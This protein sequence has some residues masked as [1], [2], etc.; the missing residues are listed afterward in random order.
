MR[1]VW[2]V[3]RTFFLTS[4]VREMEFRANFMAQAAMSLIWFFFLAMI[5]VVIFR[6]TSSV[7][8]WNEGGVLA[9]SCVSFAVGNV[10]SAFGWS[11]VDFPTNVR[12][13][14][15]DFILLKPV[16][17]Q[18][19][20]T[21]RRFNLA[22]VGPI[23]AAAVLLPISLEMGHIHPSLLQWFGFFVTYAAAVVTYYGINVF[24]MTLAVWLVRVDNLTI[25]S[26]V[27]WQFGRNP[28]QIF[29]SPIQ[30]FF[31]YLLP[32]ALFA[33]VPTEQLVFGYDG[34]RVIL[35]VVWAVVMM[36]ASR[37]FWKFALTQYSSASS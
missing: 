6:S 19:W 4:L 18:F 29:P 14:S 12:L 3:Y 5:I 36:Y 25:L 34:N 13:G 30:F 32:I 2:R 21:F 1:R 15:L 23:I 7:A 11:L 35:S 24:V 20:V 37:K 17:P 33:S 28:M 22:Q 9:L 10:Y 31:L 16:D 8:G 27:F 26:E